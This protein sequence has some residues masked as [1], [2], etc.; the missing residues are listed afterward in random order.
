MWVVVQER[1]ECDLGGEFIRPL[2][3]IGIPTR[4][5]I[6]TPGPK[7]SSPGALLNRL[8][9]CQQCETDGDADGGG[10][11]WCRHRER[12]LSAVVVEDDHPGSSS[13]LGAVG[14]QCQPMTYNDEPD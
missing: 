5:V 3:R 7:G 10:A 9:A 4:W 6:H 11:S 14:L 2:S 13:R 12:Q 8:A 1:R